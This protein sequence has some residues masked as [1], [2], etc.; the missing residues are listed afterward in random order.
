[1]NKREASKNFAGTSTVERDPAQFTG[2]ELDRFTGFGVA[3]ANFS[4]LQTEKLSVESVSILKAE[5]IA[6]WPLRLP[7]GWADGQ[8]NARQE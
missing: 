5:K 2:L 3:P 7:G 8:K 4:V 1:M 6:V